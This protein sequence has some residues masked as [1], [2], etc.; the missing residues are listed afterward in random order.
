M[1]RTGIAFSVNRL[2]LP[3]VEVSGGIW[4]LE[5]LDR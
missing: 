5:N 1:F 4:V 3:I 2:F